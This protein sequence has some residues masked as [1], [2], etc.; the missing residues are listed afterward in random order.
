M[1][2]L[3]LGISRLSIPRLSDARRSFERSFERISNF[4]HKK[5]TVQ[6]KRELSLMSTVNLIVNGT[7]GKPYYII[8]VS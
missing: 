5:E 8:T 2:R 3:S 6:M 4:F 1:S 7:I